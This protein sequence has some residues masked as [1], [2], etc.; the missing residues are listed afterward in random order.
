MEKQI[1]IEFLIEEKVLVFGDFTTKSGRKTPY[2]LNLGQIFRGAQLNTLATAYADALVEV[3]GT[4]INNLFGPAY[5]GI[6]L[7]T[8]VALQL[9]KGYNLN[10]ATS[11][12]RKEVK[13]HGE[14]GSLLGNPYTEA[15]ELWHTVIIEDVTT[16]GTSIHETLPLLKARPQILVE[17]LLVAVD[18]CEKGPSGQSA[19]KEL[20]LQYGLKTASLCTVWDILKHVQKKVNRGVW[21][22]DRLDSMLAYL[23]QY[24]SNDSH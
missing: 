20:A 17:G 1:F 11:F 19:L 6:P 12:N 22:K 13:D 24:G 5:K 16:A 3:F 9:F 4:H 8:A 10:V 2:F 7:G 14:G 18:R 23:D 21:S 15:H